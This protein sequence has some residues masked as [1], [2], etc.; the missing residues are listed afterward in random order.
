MDAEERDELLREVDDAVDDSPKGRALKDA[1]KGAFAKSRREAD[2]DEDSA[3]R[4]RG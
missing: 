1:I 2:G 4:R 3:E